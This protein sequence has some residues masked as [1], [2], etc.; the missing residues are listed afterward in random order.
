MMPMR[1]PKF[2]GSFYPYSKDDTLRFVRGALAS[3]NPLGKDL[4]RA[5]SYVAPHAGYVY[6]GGT[7]AFTYKALSLNDRLEKVNT[8]V[9]IG[10]NHTGLGKPISVSLDDWRTPVGV[11]ENDKELSREISGFSDYISMDE[12]AHAE[13]HSIEVQLPFLQLVAPGKKLC[14][15][16]M[17]DQS[18]EA[19]RLLSGAIL[20]AAEKKKRDIIV[21]ASSDF[22][23]YESGETAKRKDTQLHDAISKLDYERFN[24]L[25][26][27]LEDTTCGYGP[28][29][30]ATMFA[31]GMGASRGI[32][33]KYSNSGDQTGDYSSVVA[34][35]SVAFA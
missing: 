2:A 11:S 25:V 1:A 35:S 17:G 19:S 12:D 30:V 13:E 20:G 3:A 14:M 29:T 34:Y 22:N 10:P 32:I 8:I 33:L 18:L 27:S 7:A 5:S 6:S 24:K 21:V 28:I 4:K 23:H 16:C 9:I 31:K 15:I 26:H